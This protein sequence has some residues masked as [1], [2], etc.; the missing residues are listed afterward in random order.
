LLPVRLEEEP[1]TCQRCGAEAELGLCP[2]CGRLLC[3]A[4]YDAD[5]EAGPCRSPPHELRNQQIRELRQTGTS[6][7]V[8]AERYGLSRRRILGILA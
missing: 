6:P 7:Q 1:L 2:F 8:I 3:V 4:C 5:Q